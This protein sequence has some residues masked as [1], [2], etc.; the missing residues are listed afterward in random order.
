MQIRRI[1]AAT[2]AAV[3]AATGLVACSSDS[4]DSASGD[5]ESSEQDGPIRVGTTDAA[6]KAGAVLEE[7]AEAAGLDLEIEP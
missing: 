4:S 3:I 6:K 7:Q 2:S 1:L 5:S